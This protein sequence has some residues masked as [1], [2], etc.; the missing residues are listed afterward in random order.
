MKG[1]GRSRY[2]FNVVQCGLCQG[3]V[4]ELYCRGMYEMLKDSQR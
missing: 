1:G 3:I 2:V 4:G